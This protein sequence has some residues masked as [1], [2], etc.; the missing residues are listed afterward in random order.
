MHQ[1]SNIPHLEE[2]SVAQVASAQTSV[3]PSG[4]TSPIGFTQ[5]ADYALA[6]PT[7][8]LVYLTHDNTEP[9]FRHISDRPALVEPLG[10]H[11]LQDCSLHRH[12]IILHGNIFV[13]DSSH[14]GGVMRTEMTTFT[15]EC[16]SGTTAITVDRPVIVFLAPGY[17]VF[18]HWLVDF[19]PRMKIARQALG[20]TFL[21]HLIPVP[22]STP[23]W[24]INML[25]ELCGVAEDQLLR[26]D[27]DTQHVN[28]SRGVVPTYGHAS[29]HFHPS[30]A[31]HWPQPSIRMRRRR[32]CISRLNFESQTHGVLKAYSDRPA[33]E[34]MALSRG[35][36]LVYPETMPLRAQME[37]FGEASHVI[38]EYGSALHSMLFAPEGAIVGSIRSPNDVQIRISA[39]KRQS[40]VVVIPDKDWI[41]DSGAQ[42]YSTSPETLERFFNTVDSI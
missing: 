12:G 20:R 2:R 42:C 6:P 19:L 1:A 22:A 33:F 13:S 39:L 38:G 36:E 27:A 37:L 15:E 21:D 16:R 32:L 18:G 30:V 8:P 11:H 23:E 7:A 14:L 5:I 9:W 41:D 34:E 3:S 35:Y 24:A 26:Y 17:R 25:L 10:C 40:T 4:L 28:F 31:A 29:Y